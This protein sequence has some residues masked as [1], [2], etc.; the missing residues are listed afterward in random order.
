M[1]FRT[2]TG[3]TEEEARRNF[4]DIV[5]RRHDVPAEGISFVDERYVPVSGSEGITFQGAY[6]LR[7]GSGGDQGVDQN[8]DDPVAET[9]GRSDPGTPQA[10]GAPAAVHR[11]R[12]RGISSPGEGRSLVARILEPDDPF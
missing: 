2:G 12:D 11:R 1:Y 8:A 6:K 10:D 5:T 3:A 4:Y 9:E 7:N